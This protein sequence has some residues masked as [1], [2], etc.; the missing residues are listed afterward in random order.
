[1]EQVKLSALRDFAIKHFPRAQT[2]ATTLPADDY[3]RTLYGFAALA[4]ANSPATEMIAAHLLQTVLRLQ[5]EWPAEGKMSSYQRQQVEQEAVEAA[6]ELCTLTGTAIPWL[7][8][9]LATPTPAPVPAPVLTPAPAP[10]VPR[11]ALQPGP[12][13]TTEDAARYLGVKP[14]TMR[15]WASTDSGP[16]QPVILGRRN[17]WPTSKLERLAREGWKPRR[18]KP[19]A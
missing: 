5:I 19:A 11:P 7:A 15:A 12:N 13:Q 17:G 10:A 14:Q 18:K 8:S 4:S 2:V 9:A 16:L 1:M 6:A 3:Q